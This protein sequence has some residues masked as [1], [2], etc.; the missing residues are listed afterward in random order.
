MSAFTET[1]DSWERDY[2]RESGEYPPLTESEFQADEYRRVQAFD[3]ID[4]AAKLLSEMRD[5]HAIQAVTSKMRLTAE[6]HES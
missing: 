2:R 5:R 3:H 4:A 6:D 1:I